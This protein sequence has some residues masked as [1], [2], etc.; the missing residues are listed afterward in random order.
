L[1]LE[2]LKLCYNTEVANALQLKTIREV[3]EQYSKQYG[4]LPHKAFLYF[5]IE[6]FLPELDLNSIDIEASI[7]DGSDDCGIDAIVIDEESEL[8]PRVYFFQS[9][10]YEKE[11]AFQRHFEGTALDKIQS[12]VNDFILNGRINS[13]YQNPR[14]VD[15]LRSVQNLNGK[16]PNYSIVLCSNSLGPTDSARSRLEDFINSANDHSKGDYL[17][18]NYIDI[19]QIAQ[20][21]LAPVQQRKIDF[22]IQISGKYLTEDT[23]NARLFVGAVDAK[24]LAELVERYGDSLF[25]RNVR[26]FL[27]PKKLN[28]DI[29][30][31]ASGE[32]SPYFIYMNNGLTITCEQFTHAPLLNSPTL[33]IKNAQVVNGQQTARSLHIAQMSGKLKPDVKVLVRIVQTVDSTLLDEIVEATNSQTKVTSRDLHS[34]DNIQRLIER[35]LATKGY[36]YEARKNKYKGKDTTKRVDAEIAT[37]AYYAIFSEQPALAKDKKKLLFGEKYDELFTDNLDP[38][39]ILYAY[40]LVKT[41][42]RLNAEA[43]FSEK[44]SFLSDATL[45]TAALIHRMN[46]TKEELVDVDDDINLRADYLTAVKALANIVEE[47]RQVEGDKYEHRRTFKDPETFGRAVEVLRKKRK[48]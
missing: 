16:N 44:F 9:K 7:V 24:D 25:E 29:M 48:L 37:Q 36:F 10:F 28:G 4:L 8:R 31:T 39:E 13:A 3:V 5:V 1:G 47:R 18:V 20:Q 19:D 41:V 43:V 14:L 21:F 12:A 17:T 33:Q 27:G 32:R 46:A 35:H 2:I 6:K 45:N 30:E 42:Q 26:G 38:D 15:K 22:N 11:D 40:K 23:G 34:N